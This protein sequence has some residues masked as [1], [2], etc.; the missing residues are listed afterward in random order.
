MKVL[1]IHDLE[2]I[3]KRAENA[4][5]LREQ[6]NEAVAEQC[7]GLAAGTKHLQI[8]ICG[9]T[10]C[11]ASAS[12]VIAEKLQQALEKNKITDQV[13]VITTGCFGF[14]E[15]GP[16]VK[17]IPD[18]TFY[19]QVTPRCG[20][21]SQRT[22]HRRTEDRTAALCGPEYRKGR[23]RLQ[24]HGL[25]P[26]A[27]A[28]RPTKLRLHRPGEYRRIHRLERLPRTGRQPAERY[29]GSGNRRNKALRSAWTRRRRFPHRKEMGTCQPAASRHQVRGVQCRR[30]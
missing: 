16:I 29:A 5:L 7:C 6:S 9:G 2:A 13:N 11:K 17:I 19:T 23:Q 12:H 20:E 30:R 18:N 15:K 21:N 25:L 26:E 27:D 8:L 24:A 10:G 1:T 22:H 28:H 14:C 4:L 3:K